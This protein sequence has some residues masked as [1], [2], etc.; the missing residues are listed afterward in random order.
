MFVLL[1]GTV[2]APAGAGLVQTTAELGLDGLGFASPTSPEAELNWSDVWLNLGTVNTWTTDAGDD[3]DGRLIFG[4]DVAFTRGASSGGARA[5]V[6]YRIANGGQPL[7]NNASLSVTGT[8]RTDMDLSG[9]STGARGLAVV[10]IDNYFYLAGGATG[11]PLDVVFTLGIDGRLD[12]RADAAG[13]ALMRVVASLALYNTDPETGFRDELIA[14]QQVRV[15]HL[16]FDGQG[17]RPIKAVVTLQDTLSRYTEYNL[18]AIIEAETLAATP[19]PGS[20]GL[21]LLG[22]GLGA[23]WQRLRASAYLAAKAGPMGTRWPRR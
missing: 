13:S 11:T 16:G 5:D 1:L 3:A 12:W 15:E 4:N 7:T 17:S 21:V 6:G 23:A 10:D 18:L 22:L 14:E 19:L 20:L 9:Q 8:A 2:A